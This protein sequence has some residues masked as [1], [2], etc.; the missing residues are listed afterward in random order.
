M[1]Y[2]INF[3]D[4]RLWVPVFLSKFRAT[5]HELILKKVKLVIAQVVIINVLV[6]RRVLFLELF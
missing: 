5:F 4:R 6:S 1:F 3:L 2:L